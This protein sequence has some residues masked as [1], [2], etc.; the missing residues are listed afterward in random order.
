LDNVALEVVLEADGELVTNVEVEELEVI[1]E[2]EAELVVDV[3]TR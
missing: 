3:E 2:V 1:V